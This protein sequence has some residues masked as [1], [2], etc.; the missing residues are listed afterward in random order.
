MTR[1]AHEYLCQ[2]DHRVFVQELVSRRS[3]AEPAADQAIA[4]ACAQLAQ[5]L[6]AAAPAQP[7]AKVRLLVPA[8]ACSQP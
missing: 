7:A 8:S 2:P 1:L 6:R 5:Q 3:S 4:S